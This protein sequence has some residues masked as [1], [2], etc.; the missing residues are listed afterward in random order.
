[1]LEGHDMP[2]G[3]L[4]KVKG[5][6]KGTA[7][8]LREAISDAEEAHPDLAGIIVDLRNNPGGLLDQ[9]IEISD[10]FME[11]GTIVSTKG[12]GGEALERSTAV[13]DKPYTD[14]P[15][16][17]LINQGSASA[18]EI[19]SGA[20]RPDRA[21]LIGT[22]TFGKGSVQKLFQLPDKGALKLTV[23][24]YLTA[25]DISIQSIG[26]Q[27]DILVYASAVKPGRVRVGP[28][29]SHTAEVD[30]ENAFTDWGN[31]SEEPWAEV[32]YFAPN[33]EPS[34]HEEGAGAGEDADE[35]PRKSFDELTTEEKLVRLNEDFP[36]ALARKVL[37][38]IPG[39]KRETARRKELFAAA[40]LALSGAREAELDKL[41]KSLIEQDVDWS[42][43][44]TAIEGLEVAIK[45]DFRL[46]AG[47]TGQLEVTVRNNSA[48]A[49]HRVWGRSDSDNPFL[50][51]IDFT[52]GL[53]EPGQEKSWTAEIKA[54]KSV[55]SRWD[56]VKVELN[57]GE[58]TL[59]SDEVGA[60]ARAT[61]K[62][63][64]AYAYSVSDINEKS[65]ELSGNGI[66]DQ[67]DSIKLALEVT[68]S[69]DGTSKATEVNIRG[70]GAQRI[71][72]EAARNRL[73]DFEP[74]QTRDA[75]MSFSFEE[76]AEDNTL[77]VVVNIS[78][79]DYGAYLS[80]TLKFEVGKSYVQNSRR[81]PPTLTFPKMPPLRTPQE[82]IS[83]SVKVADD[84]EVKGIYVYLDG[85][86]VY[87]ANNADGDKLL[88]ADFT[89]DLQEGSNFLTVAASD[90]NDLLSQKSFFIHKADNVEELALMNATPAKGGAN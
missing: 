37:A 78:D 40:E 72:L 32:Q 23:A 17:I 42:G 88:E 66:V 65:P 1:M 53:I 29:P 69:G 12:R 7:E 60:I 90:Q 31:A 45:P 38:A 44:D 20:L 84:E 57:A 36:V 47:E 67:G 77:T 64:F 54:P 43:G 82:R 16:V 79:S 46:E 58:A 21:L 62:P 10:G 71:L 8:Q 4:V 39:D 70:E 22:K 56:P 9:A 25:N 26:I 89:V 24:Q 76:A 80:D 14:K 81:E 33:N 83:L 34:G 73:E 11:S 19:V 52:F 27:P 41:G 68:N 48:K 35:E 28:P 3:L 86:K 75:P 51:N 30:L 5:F 55:L 2:P 85:K 18:S 59:M 6:Q 63:A 74:G 50:K 61:V 87:Y 49:V 13:D 15:L